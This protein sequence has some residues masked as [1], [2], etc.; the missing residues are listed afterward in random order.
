METECAGEEAVQLRHGPAHKGEGDDARAAVHRQG[1]GHRR[2]SAEDAVPEDGHRAWAAVEGQDR[3][4]VPGDR[5]D[6]GLLLLP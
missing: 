6:G 4:D 2:V 3:E 1:G 5:P